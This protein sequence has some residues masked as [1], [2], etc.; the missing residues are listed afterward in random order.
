MYPL[1]PP[2]AQNLIR[3]F[4]EHPAATALWGSRKY[5]SLWGIANG[6]FP[7]WEDRRD[8]ILTEGLPVFIVGAV[9]DEGFLSVHVDV[10]EDVLIRPHAARGFALHMSIGYAVDWDDGMAE[11]AVDEIN[12]RWRGWATVLRIAWFGNGGTAFL[13]AKEPL[14]LDYNI[15]WLYA[16]GRYWKRGLH[17]S[18]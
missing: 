6:W 18:L 11:A 5:R 4:V 14:A 8:R 16:R 2:D 15:S 1:L 13:H 9:L 3:R 17:I 7:D 12:K 10:E